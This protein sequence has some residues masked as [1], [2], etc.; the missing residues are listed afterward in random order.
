MDIEALLKKV[1]NLPSDTLES[2]TIEFKEYADEKALHNA[3]DLAE[4]IVALANKSGG[5]IIIGIRDGSNVQNKQWQTQLVGFPKVNTAQVA[6]RLKG[7]IQPPVDIEVR[8][9]TF[10]N[11]NYLEIQVNHQM[12][13][14]YATTSGKYYIRDNRQSRPMHPAEMSSYIKSMK[15]YD[16]SAVLLDNALNDA[17]DKDSLESAYEN[18]KAKRGLSVDISTSEFLES[19]GGTKNGKLTKGGLLFLGKAQVIRETLGLFEFRFSKKTKSGQLELNDIWHDNIWATIKRAKANFK[20]CTSI[21]KIDFENKAYEFQSLDEIAFH[22]ALLN[23]IV[24]RDYSQEGMVSIDFLDKALII[25]SPGGFYGGVTESNIYYHDPRHRNKDLAHTLMLY[26]F[27]DRAGMGV[28]RMS[29]RSLMYGRKFPVFKEVHNNVEVRMESEYFRSAIFVITQNN[30]K[31]YG[32]IELFILNSLYDIGFISVRELE[33][34]L[35]NYQEDAWQSILKACESASM[36][37]IVE[38]SGTNDGLFVTLKDGYRKMFLAKRKL[39]KSK[40]SDR[41]VK[42]YIYLKKYQQ[43]SNEEISAEIGFNHSS[44]TSVFLRGCKYMKR[45]GKASSSKWFLAG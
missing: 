19:I 2:E 10:E 27:V 5:S 26:E 7:K 12:D 23:A 3:K 13:N 14:V 37:H 15:T 40:A 17:L 28:V 34:K 18:Y 21:M 41:H 42:L 24:H 35:A 38:L 45:T 4:E 1:K 31:N 43:A 20:K 9:H 22:E 29:I 44:Q 8:E 16:W 6:E 25:S 39:K 33:K 36:K 32:I 30:T 11:Q